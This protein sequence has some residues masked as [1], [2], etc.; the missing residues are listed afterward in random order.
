MKHTLNI[1]GTILKEAKNLI[2]DRGVTLDEVIALYLTAMVN[3]VN[4]GKALKLD[5]TM[6][7]GKYRGALV[8]VIVAADPGYLR[9][10]IGTDKPL[11]VEPEVMEKLK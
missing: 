7:F 4:Q 5:S 11:V 10:L 8:S 2:K 3:G 1:P 6:P 9:Y